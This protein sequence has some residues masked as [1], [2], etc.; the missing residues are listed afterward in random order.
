MKNAQPHII[1]EVHKSHICA[2]CHGNGGGCC[3]FKEMKN[4]YQIGI[5][6]DDMLKVSEY[7]NMPFDY[8]VIEDSISNALRDALSIT[9]YPLFDKIFYENNRLKLKTINE[10]CIF[11]TDE[12][13]NLPLEIRPLYCRVFPFWPSIDF[14]NIYVLSSSDCLAQEKSMFN[15]NIVNK[16]FNYQE[17][18]LRELFKKMR[19]YS[20]MHV[21]YIS[22]SPRLR[23]VAPISH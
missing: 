23:P 21:K 2:K 6:Y 3:V 16:H 4:D 18:Y 17:K 8:F 14:N 1:N 10:K 15:W 19:E 9:S 20:E 11:L 12:G 7:I 22:T 5:F 13:C